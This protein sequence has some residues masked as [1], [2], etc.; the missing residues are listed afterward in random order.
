MMETTFIGKPP[1]ILLD[2]GPMRHIHSRQVT[3]KTSIA[4]IHTTA[5]RR[6]C[7]YLEMRIILNIVTSVYILSIIVMAFW[8]NLRPFY[9]NHWNR[10]DVLPGE[11]ITFKPD[12]EVK[13]I[14]ILMVV[15]LVLVAVVGKFS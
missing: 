2:T 4:L 1:S 12:L 9:I 10:T 15:N 7:V 14:D 3:V 5:R 6:V 13:T 11:N 8:T